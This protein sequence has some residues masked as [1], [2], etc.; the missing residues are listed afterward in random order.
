MK[1]INFKF[2]VILSTMLV[3]LA[4]ALYARLMGMSNE[5]FITMAS[6]CLI[7]IGGLSFI[8]LIDRLY[9]KIHISS[10]IVGIVVCVL[11]LFMLFSGGVQHIIFYVV[12]FATLA[13]MVILFMTSPFFADHERLL[14]LAKAILITNDNLQCK[15]ACKFD[16][17]RKTKTCTC[18]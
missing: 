18:E 7:M 11:F 9:P 5:V 13:S 2:I 10:I 8:S 17:I 3:I 12:P 6:I 1:Y 14:K 15:L 4:A 16:K